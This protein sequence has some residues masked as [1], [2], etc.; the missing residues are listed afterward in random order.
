MSRTRARKLYLTA[1]RVTGEPM[2]LRTADR[3]RDW[4]D[5]LPDRFA[6]RCLPL[7]MA[8]QMGWELLC[9]VG[10]TAKWN[11]GPKPADIKLRFDGEPSPLV[12]SHFGHGILTFTP[13]YLFRTTPRHNLWVKGP[14][15]VWKDGAQPLEGLIE[16]DWAPY[17]FT[18]N[19]KLTRPRLKVRFEAGEPVASLLPFPREYLEDFVPR[20]QALD[21]NADVAGQYRAW[22]EDRGRFLAEL[23]LEGSEARKAGWQRDY[24]RGRDQKDRVFEGHQT[25]LRLR[26]FED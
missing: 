18:M 21:A 22:N 16:T 26:D 19:W 15:N 23:E 17:T 3:A 14:A 4:L 6:Y 13:G 25:K 24:M 8:N 10:F 7:A 5:A 11:G 9:P 20:L 1:Y 12:S 2:A